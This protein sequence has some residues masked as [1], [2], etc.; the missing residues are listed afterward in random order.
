[1]GG[2]R[3]LGVPQEDRL[4]PQEWSTPV[5]GYR[6]ALTQSG[7][8]LTALIAAI[9]CV[10]VLAAGAFTFS[11]SGVRDIALN[12][13]VTAHLARLYPVIFDAALVVAFAAALSLHGSL[14]GYAWLAILLI[15]GTVATADAVHAMSVAPPKRPIEALG[16]IVPWV[17]LLVGF[18][19]LYAMVRQALPARKVTT[20]DGVT[21][22][23]QGPAPAEPRPPARPEV[24]A[25]PLSELLADI[26]GRREE[27]AEPAIIGPAA[28][29]PILALPQGPERDEP[30]DADAEPRATPQF[31]QFHRMRSTPTPPSE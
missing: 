15:T 27:P 23:G 6:P 5:N 3:N 25:V 16:A 22:N 20:A 9:I 28:P 24:T 13:G 17:V 29:D 14:R 19:L 11:Y 1:M 10:L 4:S 30:S 18:T 8:R 21:A 31:T 7:Y 2:Q 26:P 12:A